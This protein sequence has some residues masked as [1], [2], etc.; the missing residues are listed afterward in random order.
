MSRADL[1]AFVQEHLRS[2]GLDMVL[3]GGAC[4]SIYSKDK[5]VSMDLDMIHTSLLKPKRKLIRESMAELGFAEKGRYFIHP[6]TDIFIEFPG[7]PP[8]VGEEA[9][10]DIHERKEST[11]VLKIIS[12]TDSVKDRLT[13]YYHWKDQQCLDQAI[14]VAQYTQIDIKEIQR[15]S[16]NEGKLDLFK[17]IRQQLESKA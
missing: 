6:H 3:S 9:V 2:K 11:G 12:P 1:G 15:W 13:G 4:V 8:T 16:K 5:Y 10:K 7:G 14:L 17:Q